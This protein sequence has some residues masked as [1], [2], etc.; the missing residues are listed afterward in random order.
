MHETKRQTVS[1]YAFDHALALAATEY[2]SQGHGEMVGPVLRR[3]AAAALADG[4][5]PARA[6]DKA[7]RTFDYDYT[8]LA[9]SWVYVGDEELPEDA[10]EQVAR[11]LREALPAIHD[12][13]GAADFDVDALTLHAI[14][15]ESMSFHVYY[16]GALPTSTAVFIINPK[17]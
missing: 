11:Q 4:Y 14:E 1:R 9:G 10:P 8:V 5:T 15:G 2:K 13:L 17:E 3:H 6:I 7:R 16:G 12:E